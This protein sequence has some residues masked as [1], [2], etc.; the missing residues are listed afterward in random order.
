MVSILQSIGDAFVALLDF[1]ASFFQDVVYVVELTGSFLLVLP[2][3]LSW[4]PGELAVIMVF[5][6]TVVVIYKIVGREG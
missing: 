5:A 1:V 3:Y 4:L 6:L 2:S